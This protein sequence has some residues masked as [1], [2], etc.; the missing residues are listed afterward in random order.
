[1]LLLG[2]IA[3]AEVLLVEDFNYTIGSS[4]ATYDTL[5]PWYLQ[6]PDNV[7]QITIT[8]GLEYTNYIQSGI[9]NAALMAG[10][11][12]SAIPHLKLPQ[13]VTKGSVYVAM[14]IQAT[15]PVGKDGWIMSFRDSQIDQTHFNENGRLLIN[16]DNQLGISVEKPN[17]SAKLFAAK[18]LDP[19]QVYVAVLKYTVKSGKNN[20]ETSLFVLDSIC[21]TEPS[22]PD[23]GPLKDS[24]VADINPA[25][26]LLRAFDADAWIVI[27]GLRIATTWADALG[28]EEPSGLKE[29]YNTQCTMHN[30]KKKIVN[31][32]MVVEKNGVCWS[33]LG[34]P[35][36]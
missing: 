35:I 19:Q 14:M 1:M 4:L 3:R 16:A 32:Q 9:G 29:M 27:D 13:E 21:A 17:S 6:W 2:L 33:V 28:V 36:E 26:L 25:N 34:R 15:L 31:G 12:G 23:A 8:N 30:V 7:D 24:S 11:S 20:D 18:V 5:S 22:K 10:N